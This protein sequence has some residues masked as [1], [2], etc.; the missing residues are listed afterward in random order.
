[1]KLRSQIHILSP[2]PSAHWDALD[3]A[4]LFKAGF[5]ITN[6][7]FFSPVIVCGLA[8]GVGL[9]LS[10]GFVTAGVGFFGSVIAE[11]LSNDQ[12]TTVTGM[13][14]R[15]ASS[16]GVLQA[17]EILDASQSKIKKIMYGHVPMLWAC[18]VSS[19]LT[20]GDLFIGS[21]VAGFGVCLSGAY[22]TT[23]CARNLKKALE[24]APR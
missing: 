11:S 15:L 20:T 19:F 18:G 6:T 16:N 5:D 23:R 4:L 1:M 21:L 10:L 24:F 13:G 17:K 2:K 14:Q 3:Q 8:Y 12:Q 7:A 9:N 22:R